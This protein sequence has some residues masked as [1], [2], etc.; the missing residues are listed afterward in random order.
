M[1]FNYQYPLPTPKEMQQEIPLGEALTTLKQERD[2][3]LKACLAG[4]D[5]RFVI[6]VGPCSAHDETAILDYVERLAKIQESVSEKLF[7]VPRIYTNKP[8]TTGT[9]YKGMLHQ[10]DPS[11]KPN[12]VEGIRAIR[13]LHINVMKN[14]G[15]TAADEMLYPGNYPY[16]EDLLSYVAIGARSTENQQHRLT[17]SGFDVPAGFKNP[18]SGDFQV[19]LNS[20][21][22]AQTGHIFSYNNWQVETVG[23][24]YAHTIVRGA[25][26]R[27]GHHIPNY[28]FDH[29]VQLAELYNE[30]KLENPATIIDTNH[31]NSGKRYTEQPRIAMEIIHNRHYSKDVSSLVKGLMIESFIEAG[32]QK[33]TGTEYGKSITDPCLGWADTE[34]LLKTIA[35]KI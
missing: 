18:M 24:P 4:K 14:S 12:M 27:W 35:E 26:D 33:P 6:I 3:T 31:S 25:F 19:M 10:P 22:A 1:S 16:L 17:A 11:A 34:A 7:L 5:E 23:N 8:R 21:A 9:G 30:R 15:M 2:D 13:N 28:H 29:L 20:V 32:S